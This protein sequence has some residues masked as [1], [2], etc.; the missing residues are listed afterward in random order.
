MNRCAKVLSCF[1]AVAALAAGAA[2]GRGES[3]EAISR[4]SEDVTLSFV[5]PGR[6]EKVFV[7]DGDVVKP[8][9]P[10][11]KLDDAAERLQLAQLEAQAKDTTHVR[12]AGAQLA[13]AKVDLEKVQ[14]GFEHNVATKLE[15]DHA[16]LEVTIK[17]LSLELAEFNHRQDELKHAQAKVHVGRM[18]LVSP[19]AGR[20]ET[21]VVSPGECTDALED[22]IRLVKIDP[23]WVEAPVP[24][25]S[26]RSL[27]LAVGGR[28]EVVFPD[29]GDDGEAKTATGKIIFVAAVAD[30]GSNTQMVR[31]EVPN[32]ASSRAGEHVQVSFPTPGGGSEGE[33]NTKAVPSKQGSD[34]KE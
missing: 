33:K 1:A 4:P 17:K 27:K 2:L 12:A 28:A 22:I 18:Q 25:Q 14:W 21:I 26:V 3:Y 6:I 11:V 23:L 31:V 15:V 8:G 24:V 10:L 29:Y 30:A 34:K 20:V 5:P 16:R 19:I 7:K 9:Q 13:Q 32:P